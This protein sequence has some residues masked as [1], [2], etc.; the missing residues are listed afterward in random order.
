MHLTWTVKCIGHN[1]CCVCKCI[2]VYTICIICVNVNDLHLHNIFFYTYTTPCKFMGSCKCKVKSFKDLRG[3]CGLWFAAILVKLSIAPPLGA[4]FDHH[5]SLKLKLPHCHSNYFIGEQGNTTTPWF[6]FPF[7]STKNEKMRRK[8]THAEFF[9]PHPPHVWSCSWALSCASCKSVKWNALTSLS[10]LE[11]SKTCA[12]SPPLVFSFLCL[13]FVGHV[14]VDL[15]IVSKRRW[16][17]PTHPPCLWLFCLCVGI[18]SCPPL[19][20]CLVQ[21]ATTQGGM[22][23]PSPSPLKVNKTHPPPFWSCCYMFVLLH[24]VGHCCKSHF[25]AILLPRCLYMQVVGTWR[26][27]H[28]PWQSPLEVSKTYP[29]P[30]WFYCL[31]ICVDALCSPSLQLPPWCN[32]TPPL[33]FYVQVVGTWRGA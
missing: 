18:F 26:R 1:Q 27:T 7:A 4:S 33:V 13:H 11:V 22:C 21:V 32:L 10:I 25:G 8:K 19:V 5:Q 2:D 16:T 24:C 14:C 28:K 20:H 6:F 30:F 3:E 23:Q 31:R 12:T 17:R 15:T 29:T 9:Y